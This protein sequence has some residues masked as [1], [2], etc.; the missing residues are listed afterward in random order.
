MSV[1][2]YC[3]LQTTVA[4]GVLPIQVDLTVIRTCR[5]SGFVPLSGNPFIAQRRFPS[6][7]MAPLQGCEEGQPGGPGEW[8]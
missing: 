3:S 8:Q 4:Q 7:Y 6:G 5:L 2:G 1:L